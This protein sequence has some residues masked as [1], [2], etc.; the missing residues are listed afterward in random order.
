MNGRLTWPE[1][2]AL[3]ELG[4]A[5][6]GAASP[7]L[8][9]LEHFALLFRLLL[10]LLLQRLA[11]LFQNLGVG[12]LT[13]ERRTQILQ[14]NVERQFAPGNVAAGHAHDDAHVLP[15]FH[16]FQGL[17]AN[18]D[19]RRAG[20]LEAHVVPAFDRFAFVDDDT[21]ARL[22]HHADRQDQKPQL[23]FLLAGYVKDV[24]A[25]HRRLIGGGREV[26]H[27]G[28]GVAAIGGLFGAE[29]CPLRLRRY[30]IDL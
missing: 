2:R 21:E 12:R 18:F 14:W 7:A 20:V 27:R 19:L 1:R 22:Q 26:A 23:A 30:E 11:L 15:F 4:A 25:D 10:Q 13:V 28:A 3:R 9:L 24:N 16:G 29:F 17:G 5:G 8:L 6:A